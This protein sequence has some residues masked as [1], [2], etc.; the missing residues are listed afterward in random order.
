MSVMWRS[1]GIGASPVAGHVEALLRWRR[2]GP[3]PHDG[4][5]GFGLM[6]ARCAGWSDLGRFDQIRT[7]S[8]RASGPLRL[9]CIRVSCVALACRSG[10]AGHTTTGDRRD[11]RWQTWRR[12]PGAS[13]APGKLNWSLRAKV[14]SHLTLGVAGFGKL[15][16]LIISESSLVERITRSMRSRT[17]AQAKGRVRTFGSGRV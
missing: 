16:R 14:R 4:C 11:P 9:C 12:E 3:V 1:F 10:V 15:G 7:G 6:L 13:A 17:G 8:A 5:R 2:C